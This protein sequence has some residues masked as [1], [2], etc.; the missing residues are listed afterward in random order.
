MLAPLDLKTS[1]ISEA[2]FF[3]ID[4]LGNVMPDRL[5][6]RVAEAAQRRS[7]TYLEHGRVV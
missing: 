5:A 4:Q 2:R 6:R 7:P 3:D 1:E